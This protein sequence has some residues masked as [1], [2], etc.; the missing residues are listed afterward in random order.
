MVQVNCRSLR[1]TATEVQEIMADDTNYYR[2]TGRRLPTTAS[3]HPTPPTTPRDED[4]TQ[5]EETLGRREGGR[6]VGEEY[7]VEEIL[8]RGNRSRELKTGA[9]NQSM[10]DESVLSLHSRSTPIIVIFIIFNCLIIAFLFLYL[11]I[12]ILLF[13][14]L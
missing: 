6:T 11:F 5:G 4:V 10:S 7:Q 13:I 9:E 3:L 14:Y 8:M 12:T 2:N 1:D